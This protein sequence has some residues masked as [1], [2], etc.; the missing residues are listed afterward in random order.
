LGK[1]PEG[2]LFQLPNFILFGSVNP[3]VGPNKVSQTARQPVPV[4]SVSEMLSLPLA[5][6]DRNVQFSQCDSQNRKV[7]AEPD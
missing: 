6:L 3:K 7:S 5:S 2:L 1:R 4:Y